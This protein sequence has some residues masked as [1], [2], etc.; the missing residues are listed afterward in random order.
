MLV[1]GIVLQES[2]SDLALKRVTHL[3]LHGST[4]NTLS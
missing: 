4:L 2:T 1:E 3:Y